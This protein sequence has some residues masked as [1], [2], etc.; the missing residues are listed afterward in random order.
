MY[1]L[2]LCSFEWRKQE[3]NAF[4][5]ILKNIILSIFSLLKIL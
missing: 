4:T 3:N 2:N 5:H 1:K